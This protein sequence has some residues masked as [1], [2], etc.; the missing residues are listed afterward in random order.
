MSRWAVSDNGKL[1]TTSGV[2]AG[3]DGALALI[4]AIY[5]KDK[6]GLV[7]SD[8]IAAGMEFV[9]AKDASDDPFAAPNGAKDVPP[10]A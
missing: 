6:D 5:G 3:I 8:R 10:V 2:S 7:Y 1:W 9:R 4:D